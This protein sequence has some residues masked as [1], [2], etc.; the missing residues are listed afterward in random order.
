[1]VIAAKVTNPAMA[2]KSGVGEGCNEVEMRI[3]V[4]PLAGLQGEAIFVERTAR[5]HLLLRS[6]SAPTLESV[7]TT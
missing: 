6:R 7:E 1:M 3:A 5:F 2:D 4:R